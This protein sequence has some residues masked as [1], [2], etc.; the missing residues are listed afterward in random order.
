[1]CVGQYCCKADMAGRC[2]KVISYNRCGDG[3]VTRGLNLSISHL[4]AM[5]N[6]RACT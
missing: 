1:V 5:L 3:Q 4:Y 6:T 2:Y